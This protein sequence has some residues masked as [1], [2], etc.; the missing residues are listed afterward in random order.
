[1]RKKHGTQDLMKTFSD[2]RSKIYEIDVSERFRDLI[3]NSN[4][5]IEGG[6]M[7]DK[8]KGLDSQIANAEWDL[9]SHLNKPKDK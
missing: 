1:V 5:S 9:I 4:Y 7:L 8:I 2:L 3:Y 6:K